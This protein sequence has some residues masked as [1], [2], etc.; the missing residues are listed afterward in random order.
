M[1][2]F[3]SDELK[4]KELRGSMKQLVA[5]FIGLVAFVVA[6]IAWLGTMTSRFYRPT[7]SDILL[8]SVNLPPA[9]AFYLLYPIGLILFVV[10]PALKSNSFAMAAVYGWLFGLFTYS[11]YDLSNY[12]TLRNWSLQL[13]VMDIAWGTVLAG[14]ASTVSF[15]VASRLV[16]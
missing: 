6:D 8:V 3:D 12:A 16:S 11:T 7:L 5:Y 10:D 15:W 4:L 14:I 1:I 2:E 9:V 13:T